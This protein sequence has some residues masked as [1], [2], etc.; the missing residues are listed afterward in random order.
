MISINNIKLKSYKIHADKLG[1][2]KVGIRLM[3]E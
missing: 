2:D 1:Y 3:I